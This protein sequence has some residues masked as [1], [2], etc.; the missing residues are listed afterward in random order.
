[1]R[2]RLRD[3]PSAVELARLYAVPHD[4]TR[5]DDHLLRVEM[6]IALCRTVV[7]TYW[8]VADL[9]AGDAAI[10]RALETSHQTHTTLGDL[11]P[12]WE[13]T[14]PIE[15]TLSRI[16][17]Q[18][19][20]ICS[21]TLEHLAAPDAVLRKARTKTDWIFVSTPLGEGLDGQPLPTAAA[22]PEHVWGW[23]AIE[24]RSMLLAAGFTTQYYVLVDP[25]PAGFTYAY[26]MWLA[27]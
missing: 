13:L 19:L 10:A 16:D 11:A 1:M 9:A 5:W 22:N 25:R 14:G 17:P 18:D 27:R 7:R 8:Q 15:E 4:H 21:E 3:Y 2:V 24:V 26:Q 6:S 23:D 12:G 20:L